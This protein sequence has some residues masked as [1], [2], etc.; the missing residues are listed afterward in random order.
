MVNIERAAPNVTVRTATGQAQQSTGTGDLDLPHIPSGFKIKG[1]LMSIFC[2]TLVRVG[3]L[4]DS[5][6]TVTFMRG[7]VIVRDKQGASVLTGWHEATGYRLWRISQQPGQSNLPSM[8]NDENMAT[9]ATYSAY[10]IPSFAVLIK[11]SHAATGYSVRS[12]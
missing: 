9:L 1:H 3:Q 10:D 4:C 5:D 8:P 11:Y 12:T 6:C 2:H 7:A